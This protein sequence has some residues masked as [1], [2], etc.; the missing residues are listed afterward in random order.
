MAIYEIESSALIDIELESD[1]N[2]RQT[3]MLFRAEE[4]VF[5]IGSIVVQTETDNLKAV[6]AGFYM[7]SKWKKYHAI[8]SAWSRKKLKRFTLKT[9]HQ[10]FSF[11]EISP[12]CSSMKF[13][14][15]MLDYVK[16]SQQQVIF[17]SFSHFSLHENVYIRTAFYRNLH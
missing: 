17:S 12:A 5:G 2:W 11:A 3:F 7:V 1:L 16:N 13:S 8:V 6:W 4:I 14:L 10:P 15:V 9:G